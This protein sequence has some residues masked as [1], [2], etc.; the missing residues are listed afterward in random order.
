[1]RRM[2]SEKQL[3][4]LNLKTLQENDVVVKTIEQ[5]QPNFEVNIAPVLTASALGKGLE[6][7]T[8]YNKCAVYGNIL[9]IVMV[10]KVKNPT[11]SSVSVT[12]EDSVVANIT[13][14]EKY[15]NKI[16]DTDGKKASESSTAL[17]SLGYRGGIFK[18]PASYW[19]LIG[20]LKNTSTEN[21]I[22]MR[23]QPNENVSLGASGELIYEDRI[24]IVL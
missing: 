13:I 7:E 21:Q 3:K 16:Y 22:N 8:V 1:M 14:D 2:F 18:S 4:E 15:A 6:L 23:C 24:F 19:E 11:E 12:Y 5:T 17:I 20:I 9:Y 10:N